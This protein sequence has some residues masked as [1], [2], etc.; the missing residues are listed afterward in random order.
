MT[1]ILCFG[2]SNT[3]GSNPDGTP[4]RHPY[5]VRW[6]GRLQQILGNSFQIIEEGMGGRTTVWEDPL[7][8]GRCGLSFLPVALQSHKPLDLVIL[9]LGTNDCKSLFCASERVIARGMSRLVEVVKRFD[10]GPDAAAPQILIIS[11]IHMG[12]EVSHSIFEAFDEESARKVRQ[13]ASLYE[14]IAVK[15][16]CGFLDASRVAGPGTDQLH[17]DAESHKALAEAV[18][19]M[20]GNMGIASLEDT[21]N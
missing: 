16:G 10:Y 12:K 6:P 4:A 13:L 9:S 7:E 3:H 1:T 14:E 19:A 11:P 5:S 15:Y 2:D 17:M 8:P 18:A 20:V 21:L